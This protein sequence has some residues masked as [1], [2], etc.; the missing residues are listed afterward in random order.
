V[1]TA[2]LVR[3]PPSETLVVLVVLVTTVLLDVLG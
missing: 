3:T 2:G 1:I